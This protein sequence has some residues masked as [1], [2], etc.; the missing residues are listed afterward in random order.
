MHTLYL[1]VRICHKAVPKYLTSKDSLRQQRELRPRSRWTLS[2]S[3]WKQV[4]QVDYAPRGNTDTLFCA[5]YSVSGSNQRQRT[6]S[7]LCVWLFFPH[8]EWRRRSNALI[9]A[10]VTCRCT[11]GVVVLHQGFGIASFL[12]MGRFLRHIWPTVRAGVRCGETLPSTQVCDATVNNPHSE[13]SLLGN[14]MSCSE[15]DTEAFS[16]TL[17]SEIIRIHNTN[18]F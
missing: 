15:P 5:Q 6:F 1:K 9:C 18:I 10:G 11:W 13:V 16:A 14:S 2:A 7:L 12:G 3:G 4:R 8:C 17:M